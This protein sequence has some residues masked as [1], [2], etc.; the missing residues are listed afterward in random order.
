MVRYESCL[1]LPMFQ[2]FYPS[3]AVLGVLLVMWTHLQ[4]VAPLF[5]VASI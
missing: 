2:F 5:S 3:S 1:N 4:P